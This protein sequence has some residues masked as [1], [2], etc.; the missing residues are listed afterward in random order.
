[1][2]NFRD[3]CRGGVKIGISR[4]ADWKALSQNPGRS[5]AVG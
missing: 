2:N 1:V 5:G 4:Q 3:I